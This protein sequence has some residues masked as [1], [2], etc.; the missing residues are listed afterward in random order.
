MHTLT[1]HEQP[2]KYIGYWRKNWYGIFDE[3]PFPIPN[4]TKLNQSDIIDK[5]KII[6]SKYGAITSYFGC[7]CCRLCKFSKNGNFEYWIS[8]N[9]ITYVIPVGYFHYLIE[10]NVKINSLLVEIVNYYSTTFNFSNII[11]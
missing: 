9:N 2:K 6:L 1:L 7:S 10:H 8:Y 5:T 11:N 3:Y 4:K